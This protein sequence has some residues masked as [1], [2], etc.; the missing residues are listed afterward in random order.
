V[1][2]QKSR[3]KQGIKTVIIDTRSGK[4]RPAIGI[5]PEDN[6][7]G[8]FDVMQRQYPDGRTETVQSGAK[9]RPL[10]AMAQK[11]KALKGGGP[12]DAGRAN[13]PT[14]LVSGTPPPG[15]VTGGEEVSKPPEY[16]HVAKD[17]ITP[18][19]PRDPAIILATLERAWPH[20]MQRFD[21]IEEEMGG[22]DP[23]DDYWKRRPSKEAT[24]NYTREQ[25]TKG[26]TGTVQ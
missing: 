18:L 16:P 2:E 3:E 10:S 25:T 4:E 12:N 22:F 23:K 20:Q 1:N 19:R 24:I 15:V 11:A 9:A 8:Q 7:I 17:G 21:A 5:R 13:P 14:D 26:E 6:T